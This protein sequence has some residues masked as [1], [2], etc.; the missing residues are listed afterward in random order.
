MARPEC[1][2]IAYGPSTSSG[3]S[4]EQKALGHAIVNIVPSH[5]QEVKGR[6]LELIQ[7]TRA[8]VKDRLTKEIGY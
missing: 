1:G 2:W 7:K 4:L 3:Q 8:A 5:L 6:R